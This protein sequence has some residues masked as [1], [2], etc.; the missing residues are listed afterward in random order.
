MFGV[1]FT[2]PKC[3]LWLRVRDRMKQSFALAQEAWSD[4][5]RLNSIDDH[6]MAAT[7]TEK[8]F[9]D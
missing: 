7:L 4:V 1:F 6:F 8:S 2:L 3:H 5:H 9:K